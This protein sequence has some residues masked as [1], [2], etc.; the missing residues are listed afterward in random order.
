MRLAHVRS[1]EI[2]RFSVIIPCHEVIELIAVNPRNGKSD[3][4]ALIVGAEQ[5]V[6]LAEKSKLVAVSPYFNAAL[7]GQFANAQTQLVRF[8][9][10]RPATVALFITWL[11]SDKRLYGQALDPEDCKLLHLYCFAEHVRCPELQKYLFGHLHVVI[12][13]QVQQKTIRPDLIKGYIHPDSIGF[14]IRHLPQRSPLMLLLEFYFFNYVQ[15][16]H[17]E[18][19]ADDDTRID[20]FPTRWMIKGY[21]E[22]AA[23]RHVTY[24]KFPLTTDFLLKSTEVQ[25]ESK[26]TTN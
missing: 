16:K 2:C 26:T 23:N 11:Y 19:L 9:D 5:L 25:Q 8:P 17:L 13:K 10:H 21:W 15:M 3:T 20:Q 24:K 14:A 4:V 7:N 6:V 12:A 18:Y 1:L 22:H